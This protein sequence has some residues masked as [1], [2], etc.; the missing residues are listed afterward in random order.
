MQ[1]RCDPSIMCEVYNLGQS[2]EDREIL[3]FKVSP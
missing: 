2:L 1:D 3:V